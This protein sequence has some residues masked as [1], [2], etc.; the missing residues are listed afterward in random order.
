ME[1][2]LSLSSRTLTIIMIACIAGPIGFGLMLSYITDRMPE[3][4]LPALVRLDSVWKEGAGGDAQRRLVPSVIVK[5]PTENDWRNL[6]VSLNQQFYAQEPK[7]LAS[8]A[9]VSIPLESFVARNGSVKFP[10][11]NRVVEKVLV[12]A[13]INSGA[14]AV[15]EFDIASEHAAAPSKK[16]E[17]VVPTKK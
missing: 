8:G 14:R 12:F 5:N 16:D 11:G 10:V 6:S 13:Q 15:S 17:W 3:P 9:E 2:K 4:P 1:K 7:G